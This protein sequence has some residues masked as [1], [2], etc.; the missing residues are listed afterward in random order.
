MKQNTQHYLHKGSFDIITQ[1]HVI[2]VLEW[3][4]ETQR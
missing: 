1:I 4:H 2:F 3:Q